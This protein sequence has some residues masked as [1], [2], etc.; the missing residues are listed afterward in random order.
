MQLEPRS[1]KI[2][3]PIVALKQANEW[4]SYN[5]FTSKIIMSDDVKL[6]GNSSFNLIHN[7]EVIIH[8]SISGNTL[9]GPLRVDGDLVYAKTEVDALQQ[10]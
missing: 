10:K 8:L 7:N 5:K 1:T 2:S 3:Q 4:Q 9:K 6:L